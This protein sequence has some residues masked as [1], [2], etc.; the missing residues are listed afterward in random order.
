MR[1]KDHIDSVLF[2]VDPV[3]FSLV[4]GVLCVLLV[5][6]TVEPYA[7]QWSIPGGRVDKA[8]CKNLLDGA[9]IKLKEKTGLT[10]PYLEQVCTDGGPDMDPRGWSVS[11][12][13]MALVRHEDIVLENTNAGALT[14]WISVREAL[15]LPLAFWHAQFIEAAYQRL[16]DKLLYTDL[17]IDLMPTT[18]TLA[19]LRKAFEAIILQPLHRQSFAKRML[20]AGILI[21]TGEKEIAGSRPAAKYRRANIPKPYFFP[22]ALVL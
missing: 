15:D 11:S 13:Y 4:D 5:K 3:I 16:R 14:S 7:N 2:S 19:T 17:P 1:H 8:V 20:D 6:R 21:D 9:I 10:Q 18:F 12:V 22:R